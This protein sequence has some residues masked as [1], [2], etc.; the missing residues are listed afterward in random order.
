MAVDGPDMKAVMM[1]SEKGAPIE[2]M[3]LD[4]ESTLTLCTIP[5]SLVQ[6]H[7]G[8]VLAFRE[9]AARIC[10]AVLKDSGSTVITVDEDSRAS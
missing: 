7:P 9:L 3:D 8:L 6:L 5:L 4:D 10:G 1:L 2:D